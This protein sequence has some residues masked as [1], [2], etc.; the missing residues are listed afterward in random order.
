MAI[1]W[2][3]LGRLPSVRALRRLDNADQA[4]LMT[5]FFIS[6][7]SLAQLVGGK[8]GWVPPRY[9]AYVLTLNLCGLAVVY[10]EKV[11]AWCARA[12]WPRVGLFTTVLLLIF[13]GYATQNFVAPLLARKEYL[14]PFQL[15]RFVTAFYR[16]PVA[17]DQLGYVNYDNPY[18]VLDLSD[19]RRKKRGKHARRSARSNG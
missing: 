1:A 19:S 8:I 10:R 14:G 6:V 4:K 12:S 5:I 11:V 16:G 3:W 2:M 13:A 7:V 17:V 15:Q 9:E 18:Y